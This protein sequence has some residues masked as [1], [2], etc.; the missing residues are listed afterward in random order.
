VGRQEVKVNV[1]GRRFR[2]I[3]RDRGRSKGIREVSK[4][5]V[6]EKAVGEGLQS[7][8]LASPERG[9]ECRRAL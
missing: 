1:D 4:K 3:G 9:R 5:K 2:A 6:W 8:Q 7:I